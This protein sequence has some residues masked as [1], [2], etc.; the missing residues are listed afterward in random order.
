MKNSCHRGVNRL[1]AACIVATLSVALLPALLQA[2]PKKT[3][4][5]GKVYFTD[6]NGKTSIDTGEK[7][8]DVAKRSVFKV[9]ATVIET[10]GPESESGRSKTF[11]TMVY[12]NG[13]GAFFDADTRVEIRRFQQEPFTPN[14]SDVDMEPS[15]SQTQA[16]VVRGSV[17]LCTSKLVAGS[18]MNYQ[19]AQG[20][21]NIRGRKVMIEANNDVTKI[22]ML[23]GESTVRA[24]ENDL[25]GRV[26]H[27]GEQAVIR[28]GTL[29]Q[30]NSIQI[31]RIPPQ[32]APALDDKVT[33]AC[34]ARKTVYFDVRE[35]SVA[36]GEKTPSAPATTSEGSQP[37]SG[38]AAGATTG[39]GGSGGV[40]V[41]A[42]DG[43]SSSA[44]SSAGSGTVQEIVPIPVVPVNLPVQFTISPATITTTAPRLPSG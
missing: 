44:I 39:Q 17:G 24:G 16:F 30:P 31:S 26:V 14:R 35:R 3:N 20:S 13:T 25:G 6:V 32:E 10:K 38:E 36:S 29:G 43:N 18:S 1:S 9:D 27:S 8:E 7:I 11:S 15:I 33:M 4:P 23:E 22:S 40:P 5:A 42:F 21:V 12:S 37:N 34:M 19:T 28:R 41:T 2:Q